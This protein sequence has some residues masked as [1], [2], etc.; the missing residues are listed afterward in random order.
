MKVR[1]AGGDAIFAALL[2]CIALAL[3]MNVVVRRSML[4]CTDS[5]GC[6]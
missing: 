2:Y 6:L 4:H 5:H 3:R 1:R